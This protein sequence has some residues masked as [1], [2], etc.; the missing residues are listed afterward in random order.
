MKKILVF[1]LLS[2]IEFQK[3][4]CYAQVNICS[5]LSMLLNNLF[6]RIFLKKKSMSS[7]CLLSME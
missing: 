1:G 4:K 7:T 3:A 5:Y 6:T 2:S